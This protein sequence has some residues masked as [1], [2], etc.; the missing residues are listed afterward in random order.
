M[1]FCNL[2]LECDWHHLINNK[3]SLS[4]N[5]R[6]SIAG[7]EVLTM[8]GFIIFKSENVQRG[9]T[10]IRHGYWFILF[11]V[12][13]VYHIFLSH[14][15]AATIQVPGCSL[16]QVQAVVN[17]ASRGDTV[18]IPAGAC[19]WSS[20]LT[21]NKSIILQ[22]AGASTSC[23]ESGK[24][25]ITSTITPYIPSG[26]SVPPDW[27]SQNFLIFYNSSS[28]SS[29][30]KFTFRVTG[31]TLNSNDKSG[32]I[33]IDHV[34]YTTPLPVRIDHNVFYVHYNTLATYYE[35]LSSTGPIYGV[36][37]NNITYGSLDFN[38]QGKNRY[39]WMNRT[40]PAGSSDPFYVEDNT[41]NITS[42]GSNPGSAGL[43]TG[44]GMGSVFR[45]NTFNKTIDRTGLLGI[46]CHG[47]GGNYLAGAMLCEYYGNLIN[48]SRS[49]GLAMADIRGGQNIIFNNRYN[50]SNVSGEVREF[51]T[52]YDGSGAD[53]TMTL[54]TTCPSSFEWLYGGTK[55]C[56]LDPAKQPQHVWRSYIWNNRLG[57]AGT[58]L[59]PIGNRE[60]SK[61]PEK[62]L[63]ENRQYFLHNTGC[64]G[65]SC[66]SGVGCG[67]TLPT[68]CTVG[69]GYW[70]TSQSCS[71]VP[72]GSIGKNPSQPISGTLYRCSSMN[73]WTAYYT[74]YTYP[75]PLRSG[76]EDP[77]EG[78]SPPKGFKVVN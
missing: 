19:S 69:T 24:T 13:I 28:P 33:W 32:L 59:I 71:Q 6:F 48:D 9:S 52:Y 38:L 21:I 60:V 44:S 62:Q 70:L 67:P 74:P 43:S 56:G 58:G 55:S 20:N 29:D 26:Y 2:I 40:Y 65:S 37:D 73:T 47:N 5:K 36:M 14:V 75:H 53:T 16:A 23:P 10:I 18:V 72:S 49:N 42:S 76:S 31:M 7:K 63:V 68:S 4:Y 46:N 54:A 30:A 25:C 39:S 64:S 77:E 66:T 11:V 27:Y 57:S 1:L 12:F 45:Y 41:F 61:S 50:S 22:G 51:E 34:G 8:A 15:Y 78:I 35:L 3:I 17:S